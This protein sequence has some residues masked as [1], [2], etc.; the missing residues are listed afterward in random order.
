MKESWLDVQLCQEGA[1]DCG[2]SNKT[3]R[4]GMLRFPKR[5]NEDMVIGIITKAC[6]YYQI[7]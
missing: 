4:P 6:I 2:A 1:E 5:S 3:S 7:L